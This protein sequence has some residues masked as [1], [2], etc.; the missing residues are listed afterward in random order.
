MAKWRSLRTEDRRAGSAGAA[1]AHA[2]RRVMAFFPERQIYMRSEGRVQFYTVGRG[3]Q[4]T[5]AGLLAIFL[6]WVSFSTVTVVFKDRIIAAEDH[7]FQATQ[8]AFESQIA[9]LQISYDD[10]V[11]SAANAQVYAD[12]QLVI[13]DNREQGL[14]RQSDSF[15]DVSTQSAF[16]APVEAGAVNYVSG[17]PRG[18]F[19]RALY[20][21]GLG[22]GNAH[23]PIHHPSL[24]RLAADTASLARLSRD[25]GQIMRAIEGGALQRV[26][27]EREIITGTGINADEFLR[28]MEKAEGVGGPEVPLNTV[29][30]DG[31]LDHDF[32][33][34]YFRAEANL[35]ELAD[36]RRAVTWLPTAMPLGS[37]MERTSGF[38]PRLDPFSGR[39]AFHPGVDFAG[40][41]GT[42]VLATAGGLVTFA[43]RDGG[44]GNMVE[45]DHGYGLRTR[46][47]HLLSVAVTKGQ[48]VPKGAVVGRLGSTGRS[49]GPHVH[50]EVW[51]DDTVRNPDG[52]LRVGRLAG[53][54]IAR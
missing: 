2:F 12:R 51:Y 44:Y 28:K 15:G 30:L 45:I 4:A 40:P 42:A 39:Y 37:M 52:F 35:G 46:Y 32:S 7:R 41:T 38:G 19:S 16:S 53:N 13:F 36:L 27:D 26:A 54:N 43:G 9:A 22:R 31:V 3:L 47:A 8:V 33:Q 48:R 24:D 29:Q 20:W 21:L 50:Y 17:K 11:A 5:V 1:I 18:I 10:L 25:S 23:R 49:T 34:A 6:A 14:V